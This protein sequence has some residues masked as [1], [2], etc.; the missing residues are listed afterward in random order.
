MKNQT[1]V[2]EAVAHIAEALL[3]LP[4][5]TGVKYVEGV[6]AIAVSE[7]PLVLVLHVDNVVA[8]SFL[9]YTLQV[10]DILTKT[11]DSA[12]AQNIRKLGAGDSAVRCMAAALAV[13]PHTQNLL[14]A[15]RIDDTPLGS[16]DVLMVAPGDAFAAQLS[17]ALFGAAY[18][19]KVLKLARPLA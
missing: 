9:T 17:T 15:L 11:P 8:Y 1:N 7:R 13:R 19:F 2:P 6:E 12:A 5:I 18:I 3:Q 16:V 10:R 14:K 4:G